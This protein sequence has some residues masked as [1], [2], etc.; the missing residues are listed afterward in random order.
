MLIGTHCGAQERRVVTTP[1]VPER[2]GGETYVAANSAAGLLGGRESWDGKTR[3]VEIRRGPRLARL[4]LGSRT[5]E[6]NGRPVRLRTAP[7][8]RE[9]RIMVP[10][11]R[12]AEALG[13][14]IDFDDGTDSV[15]FRED[16]GELVA[17]PL[18]TRK[19]G[20]VVHSPLP[21]EECA[22][23]VRVHGQANVPGGF[24]AQL[25]G[26]DGAVLV[27]GRGAPVP[28]GAFREFTTFLLYARPGD[29]PQPARVVVFATDRKSGEQRHE[30][31]VPITF[32]S[33]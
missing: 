25:Q 18:P 30:V 8:L 2:P 7:Y 28:L 32:R 19:Q 1:I 20:I 23:Q 13:T 17:L 29:A 21:Q 10:L 14:A 31:S 5:A 27:E 3:A 15:T 24:T 12:V 11:R 22:G 33:K 9:D 16:T 26:A 4:R 6:L